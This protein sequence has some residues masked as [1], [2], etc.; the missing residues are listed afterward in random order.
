MRLQLVELIRSCAGGDI[1][2]ALA[3]ATQQLGPRAPTSPEFLEDLEKTMALLI[4]PSDKLP[5]ELAALL[6]PE[7]RREVAD[8]VNKAILFHQSRRRNAAIRDL[9]KLRAWAENV[10]REKKKDLPERLDLGFN[11][12]DHDM[13]ERIHENGHEPMITT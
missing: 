2:P 6:E 10:A 1:S 7:L 5:P 12:D 9:V 11:G 3:F 4:F 8:K 13:D